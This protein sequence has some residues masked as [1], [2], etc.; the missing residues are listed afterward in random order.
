MSAAKVHLSGPA[1]PL[2]MAVPEPGRPALALG[3][4]TRRG[5]CGSLLWSV[6]PSSALR[7]QAV[8]SSS[9]ST[10]GRAGLDARR[11]KGACSCRLMGAHKE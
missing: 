11:H 6:A 4:R 8:N 7:R 1:R 9:D 10:T 5:S 2:A 3:P